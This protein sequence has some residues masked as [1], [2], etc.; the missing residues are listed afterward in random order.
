M[1]V[2]ILKDI[3]VAFKYSNLG[4]GETLSLTIWKAI[5]YDKCLLLK[6]SLKIGMSDFQEKM[7]P[8]YQFLVIAKKEF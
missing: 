4:P 7:D 3:K 8:S 5:N 6:S 2:K 1:P